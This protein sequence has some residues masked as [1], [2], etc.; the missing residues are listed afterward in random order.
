MAATNIFKK[1]MTKP[2][3][4]TDENDIVDQAEVAVPSAHAASHT[5]GTDD[6][7]D[8]TSS[9]KGITIAAPKVKLDATVAPTVNNDID[10]GYTVGSRWVDV[11]A[12]KEY[13]CLDNTDGAAVWTETTGAGGGAAFKDLNWGAGDFNFPGPVDIAQIAELDAAAPLNNDTG[14]NK[15]KLG[16]LMDSTDDEGIKQQLKVP[17]NINAAGTVTFEAEVYSAAANPDGDVI[18]SIYHSARAAGESW[19][20]AYTEK[21][22][23]A[24]DV[25]TPAQ[26]E[27][28]LVTWTETVVNLVWTAGDLVDF[29]TARSSHEANDDLTGD[30]VFKHL[31]IRIPTT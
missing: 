29:I 27:G 1:P 8:A 21:A 7:R 10:E 11:T 30:L 20:G 6:I 26:D 4:D 14:T 19:D 9:L 15:D 24:T 2:V 16:Y 13:V 31:R 23:A 3:Y 22:S 25:D 5:D 28:V 12:D 17:S 18:I